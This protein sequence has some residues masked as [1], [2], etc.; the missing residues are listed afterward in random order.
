MLLNGEQSACQLGRA[1]WKAQLFAAGLNTP[2]WIAST[3]AGALMRSWPPESFPVYLKHADAS[4]GNVVR[5][6]DQGHLADYLMKHP[7]SRT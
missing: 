2:P 7:R 1:N 6:V 4:T 5:L 3:S